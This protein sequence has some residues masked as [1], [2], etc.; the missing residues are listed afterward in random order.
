M[1]IQLS[2]ILF[3]VINF[4][5][6]LGLLTYLLYKPIQQIFEERAERIEK[7]QLAAQEAIEQKDKIAQYEEKKRREIEKKIASEFEKATKEAQ[8][9]KSSL[10]DKAKTDVSQ[11]VT[12]Q[13]Q[14]W[15]EEKVQM[16]SKLQDGLAGAVIV[17]TERVLAKKLT[18]QD[19]EKLVEQQLQQA[20]Q[21]I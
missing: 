15:E 21:E 19:K 3:Q 16:L 6:V 18:A 8:E 11:F 20:L 9:L 2:Q 7:G 14:K 5:V 17:A 12:K 13:Q 1:D 4:S 10:M